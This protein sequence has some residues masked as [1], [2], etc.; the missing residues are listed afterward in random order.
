MIRAVPLTQEML[1]HG[2]S[3][4]PG[5]QT[6]QS[7]DQ[8]RAVN[9]GDDTVRLVEILVTSHPGVGRVSRHLWYESGAC[10]A[11]EV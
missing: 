6:R 9:T 11:S 5:G 1:L 4:L 10:A 8:G 7:R 2:W 3:G